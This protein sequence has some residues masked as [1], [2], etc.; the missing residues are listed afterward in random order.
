MD[1][2]FTGFLILHPIDK[3]KYWQVLAP[4]IYTTI[5]GIDIKI[6]KYFKTDFASVPRFLW[7]ILPPW[8]IYGKA[9][10]LHDFLYYSGL[11]TKKESD[12]I[13]LEAMEI[14]EVDKWKRYSMYYSARLFGFRP[15][16]RYRKQEKEL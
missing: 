7:G 12:L 4:L 2:K 6:P 10:I 15:W 3:T 14:L 8:G 1:C 5:N 16:N 13:F 9:A 11:F